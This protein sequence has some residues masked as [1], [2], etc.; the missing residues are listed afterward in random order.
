MLPIRIDG[1]L[2]RRFAILLRESRVQDQDIDAT[3]GSFISVFFQKQSFVA[4]NANNTTNLTVR[5]GG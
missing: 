4:S 5:V 2:Q 1:I 3:G